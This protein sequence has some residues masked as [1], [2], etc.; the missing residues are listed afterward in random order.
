MTH[1][2]SHTPMSL[3]KKLFGSPE[4]IARDTK[5]EL[6]GSPRAEAETPRQPVELHHVPVLRSHPPTVEAQAAIILYEL[7]LSAVTGDTTSVELHLKHM[8]IN[9]DG[10]FQAAVY[11][12][13]KS[14][15]P[16]DLNRVLGILQGMRN[17]LD[18]PAR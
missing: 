13:I 18:S 6:S 10:A 15:S 8:M 4:K 12:N 17:R 3:W 5:P 1:T 11:A 7:S 2:S 14:T 9:T 16:E